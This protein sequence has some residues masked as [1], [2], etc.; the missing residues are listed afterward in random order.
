MFTQ[1]QLYRTDGAQLPPVDEKNKKLNGS[2]IIWDNHLGGIEG[3]RQKGWTIFTICLLKYIAESHEVECEI[4]GQGDNQVLILTYTY[5]ADMTYKEQHDL[6]MKDLENVLTMI[7]PPLKREETWDSSNFFIYGK[8][9][10]LFGEPMS[11]SLKKI[12]R[13]MRLTNENQTKHQII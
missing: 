8:Y 3:L 4:M 12:C 1:A 10:V 6:L 13:T 11:M 9:P 2:F 5:R 7:G